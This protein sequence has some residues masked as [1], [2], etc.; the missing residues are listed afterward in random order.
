MKPHTSTV[1]HILPRF[2][3]FKKHYAGSIYDHLED[4]CDLFSIAILSR[5]MIE[6]CTNLATPLIK[7][8]IMPL[9]S[10]T[11]TISSNSKY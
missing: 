11:Y 10:S 9:I 7:M 1:I 8:S 3:L 2:I 4:N 5:I 6:N